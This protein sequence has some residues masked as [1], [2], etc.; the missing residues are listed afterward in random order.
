VILLSKYRKFY[1]ALAAFLAV[2]AQCA[3]DS[4][5]T[6]EEIGLIATALVGALGVFGIANRF[7]I[8]SEVSEG[9]DQASAQVDA[10]GPLFDP[11]SDGE[12]L[13]KGL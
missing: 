6:A 11:P 8:P 13:R 4:V 9:L 10:A 3:A 5:I 12:G 1:V 2:V 7:P